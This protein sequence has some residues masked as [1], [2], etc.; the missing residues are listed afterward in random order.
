[1]FRGRS[2]KGPDLA[3]S[4]T[5]EMETVQVTCPSCKAKGRVPTDKLKAGKLKIRCKR[6]GHS[7]V[8]QHERRTYYRKRALP[9]ARIGSVGVEF[10]KLPGRAYV[11]DLSMTGMRLKA[12]RAPGERFIN[13]RFNL[14]PQD[15]TVKLAGEVVWMK[16]L[17]EGGYTF[18]IQFVQVD[19]YNKKL[20]GFFL[21]A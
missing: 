18:G 15:E 9:M 21:M 17:D 1:M 3:G 14:P 11:M 19:A 4:Q 8:F 13:I 12:E 20:L 16:A 7:F 10:D 6:C 5:T 2:R